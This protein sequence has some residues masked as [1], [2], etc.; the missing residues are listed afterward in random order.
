ME[1]RRPANALR[2]REQAGRHVQADLVLADH[3]SPPTPT[4]GGT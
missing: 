2:V 3:S 1:L 4:Q